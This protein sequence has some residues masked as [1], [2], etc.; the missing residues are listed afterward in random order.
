MTTG[1]GSSLSPTM[2]NSPPFP[3]PAVLPISISV[4]LCQRRL[5]LLPAARQE[6]GPEAFEIVA[7]DGMASFLSSDGDGFEINSDRIKKLRFTRA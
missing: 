4:M 3:S 7:K 2:I 1:L 6:G 5:I